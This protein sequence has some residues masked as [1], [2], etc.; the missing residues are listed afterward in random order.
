MGKSFP[1]QT[2]PDE[3]AGW[4]LL[5][6]YTP[7]NML[8]FTD[9]H[10]AISEKLGWGDMLAKIAVPA[11]D[12]IINNYNRVKKEVDQDL[13]FSAWPTLEAFLQESDTEDVFEF[14]Y[15]Q[16]YYDSTDYEMLNDFTSL[17]GEIESYMRNGYNYQEA[18][19]E[20]FK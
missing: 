14:L 13:Q 4:Y 7:T 3:I 17:R 15:I 6:Y 16:C 5:C 8:P 18:I 20:W 9:L 19:A 10:L 11:I 1:I 2:F 12:T